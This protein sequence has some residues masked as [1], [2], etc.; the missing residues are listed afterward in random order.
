MYQHMGQ[1][2]NTEELGRN[3]AFRFGIGKMGGEK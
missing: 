2:L 3:A 1:Y